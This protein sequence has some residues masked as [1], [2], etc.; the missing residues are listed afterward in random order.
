MVISAF[1]AARF[2]TIKEQVVSAEK[3][4]I[5]RVQTSI[6]LLQSIVDRGVPVQAALRRLKRRDM[7]I[8]LAVAPDKKDVIMPFNPAFTKD[9]LSLY[10]DRLFSLSE[11]PQI[12]V[13]R[14]N[15][16]ELIGPFNLQRSGADYVVFSVRFLRR[17]EREDVDFT[18]GVVAI[19]L[20]G[21]SLCLWLA[22]RISKPINEIREV[23][24]AF[25]EGALDSRIHRFL[26][27]KDEIGALSRDFNAMADTV[28]STIEQQ[29]LL[30]ANVSHELR[31]PLTRLQLAVAM[32]ESDLVEE[33]NNKNIKRI[34]NEIAVMDKLIGDVINLSK[35]S[36]NDASLRNNIVFTKVKINEFVGPIVQNLEF[37][38][39]ANKKIL[40]YENDLVCEVELHQQTMTSVI[41]NIVRNAIRF[42]NST[43]SIAFFQPDNHS[44]T[45]RISDDGPGMSHADFECYIQPF[46]YKQVAN[47]SHK[48]VGLGLAIAEAGIGLHKGKLVYQQQ[49]Q[50]K[51]L[52]LDIILPVSQTD[53][54]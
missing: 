26:K 19:L 11:S 54:I 22:W 51:G 7:P 27:S 37:E 17:H 34:E 52:V 36:I 14:F 46:R 2:L 24:N 18:L 53:S 3:E 28:A 13:A 4:Q 50:D 35:L 33:S 31:T 42:A 10:K 43:I 41:E 6:E 9:P 15:N 44:I 48:S 45:I 21:T 29:K 1:F 23:T 25:R 32:L 40:V 8:L 16:L 38:A 5:E 20:V 39:K 49:E 47:Q 30:M 12:L